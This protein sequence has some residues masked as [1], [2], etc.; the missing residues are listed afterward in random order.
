MS[1]STLHRSFKGRQV[2]VPHS[3]EFA[4]AAQREASGD[5][6]STDLYKFALQ[7]DDKSLWQLTAVTPTWKEVGVQL[8][9]EA[10]GDLLFR[11]EDGVLA[12]LPVGADGKILGAVSGLPGWVDGGA[13]VIG[14]TE[15]TASQTVTVPAGAK[16]ALVDLVGAG[17]GGA[18]A[19]ISYTYWN[20]G[21]GGGCGEHLLGLAV[22]LTPGDEITCTIGVGGAAN[23]NGGATSFGSY[24]TAEGGTCTPGS[25]AGV[26]GDPVIG[27]DGYKLSSGIQSAPGAGV[28]SEGSGNYK[29]GDGAAPWKEGTV[30]KGTEYT[31]AAANGHGCGGAGGGTHTPYVYNG[32]PGSDGRMT[33]IWLG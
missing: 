19:Y 16:A 23:N 28:T 20:S 27:T 2:H 30:A 10:T 9:F 12:R 25:P 21:G 33:I 24:L 11:G 31:G 4:N 8:P 5:Y 13:G 32:G 26:N 18:N 7:L 6:V 29:G 1:E 3:F 15:L 17:A 22:N 14:V